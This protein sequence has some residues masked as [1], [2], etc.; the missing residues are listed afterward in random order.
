MQLG[1]A[2]GLETVAEGIETYDQRDRLTG[3]SVRYGHGF[4]F[5]RPME[6]EDLNR[7]LNGSPR[8]PGMSTSA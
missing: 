8:L 4:L 6:F 2:L 5:V 1:E 3:E 7:I